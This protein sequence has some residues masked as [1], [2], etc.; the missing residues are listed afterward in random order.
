MD[1]MNETQW[2]TAVLTGS[3]IG[4]WNSMF[5]VFAKEGASGVAVKRN[6]DHTIHSNVAL[7][8]GWRPM[9]SVNN[10]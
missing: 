1:S 6:L 3:A 7:W 9:R 10:S 4:E 8:S 2:V 5:Y